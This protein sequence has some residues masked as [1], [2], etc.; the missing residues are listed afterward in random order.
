[1]FQI[2]LGT[3]ISAMNVVDKEFGILF[4]AQGTLRT[5]SSIIDPVV[6]ILLD[7]NNAY[8]SSCNYAYIPAFNRYYYVTNIVAVDGIT[9]DTSLTTTQPHQIWEFHMH[10]DVLM[11]FK[12]QIRAQSAVVARQEKKY[13]LMLDDGFFMTYQNPKLQTK[14]FSVPDPFETQEFVLVVAGS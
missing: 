9:D 11:S 4:S 12:D 7:E 13:N 3:N 14:L 1:M 10:V 2:Q 8:R 5:P 6:T